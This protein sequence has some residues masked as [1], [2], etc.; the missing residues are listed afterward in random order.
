MRADAQ[1]DLGR[2]DIVAP[3]ERQG[4]VLMAGLVSLSC[5]ILS[6]TLS[7]T[8]PS[9]VLMSNVLGAM[10]PKAMCKCVSEL[11]VR[12]LSNTAEQEDSYFQTSVPTYG[13]HRG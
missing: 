6:M 11:T 2:V 5:V 10:Y 9:I 4:T 7:G 13:E 1:V 3:H 12:F 8:P